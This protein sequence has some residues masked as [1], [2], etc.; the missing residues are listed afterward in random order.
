M[1]TLGR[2]FLLLAAILSPQI[3]SA[4]LLIYKGTET[5][6]V[7]GEYNGAHYSLRLIYIVDHDSANIGRITYYTLNGSKRHSKSTLTN[8][9]FVTVPGANGKAYTVVARVPTDCEAQSDPKSEGVYLE[10]LNATLKTNT[11][12]T[13]RFPRM[14]GD[15]G[16]GL[17]FSTRTGEPLL[18]RGSLTLAFHQAETFRSN[19]AG[20][21]LEDALDRLARYV[22]SLGY[23]D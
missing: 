5:E 4:E 7:A 2:H 6:T 14:F 10:G 15:S 13:T 18:V 1:K 8:A 23:V 16:H 22:E 12:A 21:T 17:S 19:Q 20:E 11:N 9:H 3:A